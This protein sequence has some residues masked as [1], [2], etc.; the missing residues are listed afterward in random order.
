MLSLDEQ[1]Q[2]IMCNAASVGINL[3]RDM[4]RGLVRVEYE[5]P[6]Q[7]EVDAHFH[8]IEH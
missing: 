1:V 8:H 4:D 6:Q 3:Q 7:I 2:K 5:P